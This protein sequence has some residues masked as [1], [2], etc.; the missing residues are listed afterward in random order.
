MNGP[1]WDRRRRDQP[2]KRR[3]DLDRPKL[4]DRAVFFWNAY[5]ATSRDRPL[6]AMGGEGPIPFR[7]MN[8]YADEVGI[9][10]PDSRAR[11]REIVGRMDRAYLQ[12]AGEVQKRELEAAK[13][14]EK[15]RV[16]DD[17]YHH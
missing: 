6:G 10:D 14:G 2:V 8:E 11:L 9:T 4:Q 1:I 7:S 15:G 12:H 17:G 16:K 3:P 13:R 5:M